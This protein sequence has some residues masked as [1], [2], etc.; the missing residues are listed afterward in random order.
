M[1]FLEQRINGTGINGTEINGSLL[2]MCSSTSL[3]P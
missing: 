1:F 3:V 2:Q